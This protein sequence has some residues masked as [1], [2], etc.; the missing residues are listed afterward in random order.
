MRIS[1]SSKI[2]LA[3]ALILG[4]LAATTTVM[5]LGAREQRRQMDVA[6]A[7]AGLAAGDAHDLVATVQRVNIDIVQI[8]QWLTDVSATRAQDGLDDGFAE[9]ADARARATKGLAEALQIATRIGAREVVADMDRVAA[10]LPGFYDLGVAMAQ[11]YVR[12][13]P[14]AGNRMMVH[15]DSQTEELSAALTAVVDG[16]EAIASD[17][18]SRMETELA[19]A[20]GI[21]DRS[22]RTAV[23]LLIAGV[24]IALLV[25][26]VLHRHMSV[27]LAR[28]TRVLGRIGEGDLS[29]AVPAAGR[30]SDEIADMAR[31][32]ALLH[33]RT[34]EN[35]RLREQQAETRRRADEARRAAMARMAETVERESRVAVDRVAGDART[36]D[37]AARAMALSA[38]GVGSDAGNVAA[39]A[40]QALAN[41][42]AVASA[43]EELSLSIREIAGQV[44]HAMSVS[45]EA[46]RH[47]AH[48]RQTID[49]LSATVGQ[50][51]EVAGLIRDIAEQTNLLALNATIEAA[52]AG[53]AGKG[54]AVVASEVKG[55]ASQTSRST[56]VITA[57]IAE[58][59]AVTGTAVEAVAAIARAIG[60]MDHVSAMIAAAVE[61]QTAA[62]EEIARNVDQTATAN[63]EVARRIASVSSE[64]EASGRK[65]LTVQEVS[66]E[67]A[68]GVRD[69]R[70]ALVRAVRTA[71]DE[72]E[73]GASLE[74]SP[75]R[76]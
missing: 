47:G 69:L 39:A 48:T 51:S 12:D 15:L 57:K 58:I 50:I 62:T 34:A 18:R 46:V 75:G 65:A 72:A 67:V 14:A 44:D 49:S 19:A 60:E 36:M 16:V 10:A 1:L 26:A 3:N 21:A 41:A 33:E 73:G 61:Q 59:Q 9:A 23:I 4:V 32:L 17:A 43:T 45:R 30:R 6:T 25:M 22:A 35:Q 7:A 20:G 8:Q 13:G 64:A 76:G 28:M 71:T 68:R 38:Q 2:I 70:E 42:Q 74:S 55:L 27:P 37:E 40:G 52:R 66:A 31:N 53:E 11:A 24:A 63:R 54:F 5:M 29:V 56:E